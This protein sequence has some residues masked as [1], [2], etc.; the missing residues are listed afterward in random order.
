MSSS[1]GGSGKGCFEYQARWSELIELVKEGGD[2]ALNEL[3]RLLEDK[4]RSI[5]QFLLNRVCNQSGGGGLP[6]SIYNSWTGDSSIIMP[7]AGD[8]FDQAVNA[9]GT[10]PAGLYKVDWSFWIS[11]QETLGAPLNGAIYLGNQDGPDFSWGSVFD[12]VDTGD[13]INVSGTGMKLL[14]EMD[15]LHLYFYNYGSEVY[16]AQGNVTAIQCTNDG[17]G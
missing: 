3:A 14:F 15:N 17:G 10:Q 11:N 12:V 5:E 7:A 6:Y 16:F 4:D 9:P 1:S 8:F 13:M 2:S